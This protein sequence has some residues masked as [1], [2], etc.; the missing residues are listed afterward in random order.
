VQTVARC[1]TIEGRFAALMH[2]MGTAN[3]TPHFV[4]R[5]LFLFHPKSRKR[6]K[7]II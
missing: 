6:G 4:G 5:I 2:D 1:T 3:Y 7:E